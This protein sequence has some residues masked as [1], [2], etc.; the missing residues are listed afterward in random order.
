MRKLL[1]IILMV[2]FSAVCL[3][4]ESS[5]LPNL[6][7]IFTPD[8]TVDTVTIDDGQETG[9]QNYKEVQEYYHTASKCLETLT[10]DSML[11]MFIIKTTEI[12]NRYMKFCVQMKTMDPISE[13]Q[14][15]Q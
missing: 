10:G 12:F 4:E 15:T 14:P 3:G 9:I 1:L 11:K 2:C 7:K 6:M 13:H 5:T 8:K